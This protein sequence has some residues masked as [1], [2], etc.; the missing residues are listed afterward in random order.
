MAGDVTIVRNLEGLLPNTGIIEDGLKLAGERMTIFFYKVTDPYGC[1]SNFS[2]HSV[3]LQGHHWPTSEHFYQAQKYQGMDPDLCDRI[4]QAPT[5]EEAAA[6]GRSSL[7]P[8]RPDWEQ[9]KQ[10]I[11][12]KAVR[13][14]FS[15]HADIRAI[16]LATGEERIVEDSPK[17]DYW[18]CGLDGKGQNY[19]GKILMQVRQ[20]LGSA[21]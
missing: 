21:S 3:Y 5:P 6:L 9:V 7:A 8:L 17:D 4:R 15:N 12:Y 1:F 18:G 16:L 20:E 2:L 13:E 11:M 10:Q 19:L 14:K